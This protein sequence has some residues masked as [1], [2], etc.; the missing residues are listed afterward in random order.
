MQPT[1]ATVVSGLAARRH[2]ADPHTAGL[3]CVA[4]GVCFGA[5]GL[6]GIGV[7]FVRRLRWV[8]ATGRVVGVVDGKAGPLPRVEYVDPAGVHRHFTSGFSINDE[9]LLL[10][11]TTVAVLVNPKDPGEGMINSGRLAGLRIGLMVCGAFALVGLLLALVGALVLRS[12]G[13]PATGW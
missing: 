5:L 13:V 1:L 12:G 11:G 3:A 2:G 9:A 4:F 7:T 6:L 8:P 10:E